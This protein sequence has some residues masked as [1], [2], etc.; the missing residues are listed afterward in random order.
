MIILIIGSLAA[1]GVAVALLRPK[2]QLAE[3][4]DT[5][6]ADVE[7]PEVS[8]PVEEAP[9]AYEQVVGTLDS[10]IVDLSLA[11]SLAEGFGMKGKIPTIYHNPGDLKPPN[12]SGSYW[13]GQNGVGTGG[14]AIFKSDTDGWNALRKQI[15]LWA[16]N[17]SAVVGTGNTFLE[18]AQS[19]AEDWQPWIANVL[20]YLQSQGHNVTASTTLGDYFS[21]G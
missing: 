17:K 2:Q 8:Q 12:G 14:H 16:T 13:S 5:D 6:S 18:L 1:L 9:D 19:Y 15:R 10:R 21:H 3:V 20:R 7:T 4:P 11:I